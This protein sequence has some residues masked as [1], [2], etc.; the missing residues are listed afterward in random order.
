MRARDE[1][2]LNAWTKVHFEVQY[3]HALQQDE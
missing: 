2:E 1:E 3:I